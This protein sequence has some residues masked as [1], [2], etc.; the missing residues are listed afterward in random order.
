[1]D[2]DNKKQTPSDP[3]V[4]PG[5]VNRSV[6]P[7]QK[8]TRGMQLYLCKTCGLI[9]RYPVLPAD[10]PDHLYNDKY[11]DSWGGD[12]AEPMVRKQKRAYFLDHLKD[13]KKMKPEG[14]LLDLGCAKGYF[15]ELALE[16]GY[17]AYG[18]D[19][20]EYACKAAARTVGKERIT[21]GTLEHSNYAPGTFDVITMFD[22]IEH[23]PDL[24]STIKAVSRLLKNDGILYIVTPSTSS[25]SCKIM[26]GHWWH[27]KEEHLYYFDRRSLGRLL[28]RLG[29]G[30]LQN[31]ASRKTLSLGYMASQLEAY[32][33]TFLSPFIRFIVRI[34]PL[35]LRNFMITLHTGEFQLM[36]RRLP[37]P[38]YYK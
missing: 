21:P 9:F 15:V 19:I 38:A 20:S 36:A 2:L 10:G 24:D 22:Y 14:T 3:L 8:T 23:V 5:C 11:F 33:V 26:R 25:L 12:Q 18:L 35:T 27:Y 37:E 6:R 32:P 28:E 4:C 29:F 1:M 16:Q 13:I 17:S 30:V 34:S 31:R 7:H